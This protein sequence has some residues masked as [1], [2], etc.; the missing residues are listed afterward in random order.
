[1]SIT[2]DVLSALRNDL[3]KLPRKTSFTLTAKEVVRLTHSDLVSARANGY[4]L[5]D[6]AAILGKRGV[7]IS[8]STLG[9]YL[10]ALSS[11][12]ASMQEEKARSRG[13]APK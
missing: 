10:R 4:S 12:S 7:A 3:T 11:G 1:M 9:T 6:L 13:N 2:P 5:A 8:A